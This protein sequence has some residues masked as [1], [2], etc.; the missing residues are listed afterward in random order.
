MAASFTYLVSLSLM[1]SA[2]VLLCYPMRPLSNL[3]HSFCKCTISFTRLG[4]S[5]VCVRLT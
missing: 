4:L 3:F 5:G 2:L 1:P